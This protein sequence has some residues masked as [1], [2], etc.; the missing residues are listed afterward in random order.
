MLRYAPSPYRLTYERPALNTG[1]DWEP[2]CC[3]VRARMPVLISR[4]AG[5]FDSACDNH[6]RPRPPSFAWL[7]NLA[8]DEER[9]ALATVFASPSTSSTDLERSRLRS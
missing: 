2:Y 1:S 8:I 3:S 6:Q 5:Q 4:C 9:I 7:P